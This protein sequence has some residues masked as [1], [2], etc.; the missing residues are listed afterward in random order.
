[1]IDEILQYNDSFVNSGFYKHFHFNKYPRKRLAI[2]TCMDTRL[3]E[4]LPAAL[5]IHNGN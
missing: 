5:G 3:V 2:L 4:L 1:M